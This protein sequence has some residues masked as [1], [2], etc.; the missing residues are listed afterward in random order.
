ML[1]DGGSAEQRQRGMAQAG[2]NK[3]RAIQRQETVRERK[4]E[5]KQNERKI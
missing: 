3:E 4:T 5:I 1:V 2:A